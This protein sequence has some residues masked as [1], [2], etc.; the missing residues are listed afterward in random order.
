VP[1]VSILDH[2]PLKELARLLEGFARARGLASR[3]TAARGATLSALVFG[4][5]L[6]GPAV[7]WA[8]FRP[9]SAKFAIP[10]IIGALYAV[11]AFVQRVGG[12]AVEAELFDRVAVAAL[13]GDV[14]GAN[15]LPDE[16]AR[17][18]LVQAVH[19]T[20]QAMALLPALLVDILASAIFAVWL[21]AS[22]PWSLVAAG[23]GL[24]V[25]LAA[26]LLFARARIDRAA[27]RAW[28]LQMRVFG[29]IVD[30]LEGRLEIVAAGMRDEFLADFRGRTRQWSAA[31][32][33]VA[34]S[35]ALS[36][37]LPMMTIVALVGA[38]LLGGARLHRLPGMTLRDAALFASV[39][40]A[41]AGIAQGLNGWM[42]AER[43][44]AV[45]A[46]VLERKTS[47][48]QTGRSPP[49]LPAGIEVVDVAFA[50]PGA[51]GPDALRGI[52]WTWPGA[53]ALA[54]AGP[55]G[56]GKS[57][58]LRLL[59]RLGEPRSGA[60]RVGGVRL[61]DVDA[62][63]WRA[64]SAFMPQRPYLP[65]RA[66]VG[67]AILWLAATAPEARMLAALDRVGLL[68]SLRRSG[69]RPLDVRVDTLSVGQRQRVALARVLCRDADLYVLDEPDANLDRPGILLVA[70][71]V[72]ELARDRAVVFAAHSPELL[73]AADA[74][75]R[76]DA[77]R[78]VH[79][80]EPVH[81][82]GG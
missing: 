32:R 37:R 12:A 5:R 81:A 31:G 1:R 44:V 34:M 60:I 8:A 16:D 23:A 51:S 53:G 42:N 50:Y 79:S 82:S 26:I 36:G 38:A 29:G 2:P 48:S 28:A 52:D 25:V 9:G 75:V 57:T 74:I 61:A 64:R 21:A 78:V 41:F 58:C 54:L 45:L 43:W 71:L 65:P 73:E 20:K 39:V 6:L 77:G 68:E 19:Y 3:A 27:G 15:L 72:R 35:A 18:E 11:Q 62:D 14:V 17:T 47:R 80:S 30:I 69:D 22:E 56:S 70:G 76:F 59:L 46:R 63:A 7:A 4:Q 55:N 10:A 33:T 67:A 13:E 66:S 24:A 49:R 40:P